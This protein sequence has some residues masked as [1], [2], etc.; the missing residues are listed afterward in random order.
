MFDDVCRH[1]L[2]ITQALPEV[3][4]VSC[5]PSESTNGLIVVCRR[6]VGNIESTG[7]G[8]SCNGDVS[9]ISQII[10]QV[11]ARC[12]KRAALGTPFPE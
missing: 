4:A 8:S 7:T 11:V 10:G 9:Q 1:F 12:C 5:E 3:L 2:H 6:L